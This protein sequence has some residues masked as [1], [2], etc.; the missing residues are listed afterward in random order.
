M[1]GKYHSNGCR[2][3]TSPKMGHPHTKFPRYP[4]FVWLQR[5]HY[6]PAVPPTFELASH[7]LLIVRHGQSTWNAERRG[8]GQANPP[9][10]PQVREEAQAAALALNAMG[11]LSSPVTSSDL[12]RAADTA[13]AL[14]GAV[15]GAVQID[16][17]LRERHAGAWEG[18]TH[19]E[20]E[21]QWPGW[22]AERRRPEGFES[23]ESIRERVFAALDEA[24]GE[25]RQVV[26]SHGG[27]MRL[28]ARSY[29]EDNL[30]PRNLDAIRIPWPPE[31]GSTLEMIRT[32]NT[33]DIGMEVGTPASENGT[34]TEDADR[35]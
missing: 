28:V 22:L 14:S 1:R 9:L 33:A 17:R 4:W 30:I 34:E 5:D 27:V 31:P 35:V 7:E 11:L 10:S 21:E 12:Q 29:G 18:H 24:I 3:V 13:A 6:P 20:I 23:D 26:V 8:Q 16:A 2:R 25:A 15:G 19:E 32:L